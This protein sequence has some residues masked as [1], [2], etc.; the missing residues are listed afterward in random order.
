MIAPQFK[1]SKKTELTQGM[2]NTY[3]SDTEAI[4]LSTRSFKKNSSFEMEI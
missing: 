4:T 1:R 2:L 3:G